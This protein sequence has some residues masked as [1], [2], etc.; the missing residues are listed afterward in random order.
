M[1]A[2]PKFREFYTQRYPG[3]WPCPE[4]TPIDQLHR[5]LADATADYMDLLAAAVFGKKLDD[6]GDA[7]ES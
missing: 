3:P 1:K 4:G 5:Q 7:G 2:P 6:D